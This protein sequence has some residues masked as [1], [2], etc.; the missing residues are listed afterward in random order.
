MHLDRSL[1]LAAKTEAI[2]AEELFSRGYT[3]KGDITNGVVGFRAMRLRDQGRNWQAVNG[4]LFSKIS[5]RTVLPFGNGVGYYLRL[6]SIKA[7]E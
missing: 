4:M 1:K 6:Q 7:I 5:G 3:H 2:A